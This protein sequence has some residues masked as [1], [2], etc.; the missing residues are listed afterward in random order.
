[1]KKRLNLKE[2]MLIGFTLFSMFFGAGNLIFPPLVGLQ[3]GTDAV[4]AMAGLLLSAV[5][6]PILG[7]AAVARCGGLDRLAGRVHPMFAAV[8]TLLI[9][10]MIGPGL[11]IPRT[12]STSFEMAAAPFLGSMG[13]ESGTRT[14]VM[15]VYSILF[16]GIAFFFA[17]RP[18][19]LKDMLGKIMTPVLL[20]LIAVVF[21]G[22]LLGEKGVTASPTAGYET[23]AAVKG[24]VDG[25]QT[26]DTIA[27]LNFG[28]VIAMNIRGMGIEK[29]ENISGETIRAGGIAGL[30][31]AVVYSCLAYVGVTA[32]GFEQTAS[33][34]ADVLTF[35]VHRLFGTAG[36]VIIALI[37]FIA[38]LNVC[39]GLLSCCSEYFSQ[40]FPAL[41][42]RGWLVLFA[43]ASLIVSNAGLNTIIR[44]SAPALGMIYP[45]AIVLIVLAFL[46]GRLGKSRLFCRAAVAVTAVW[47]VGSGILALIGR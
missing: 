38:C 19:R 24:F 35:M 33:N 23:L 36:T 39:I 12:A 37:F 29:E 47:S 10:L 25:Y 46:P 41:G 30:L 22:S 20:A 43:G 42:Y 26:M 2:R 40:T 3:A 34:G 45:V 7:V 21:L 28:I 44:V 13:A 6:L 14:A 17:L 9:Y 32:S 8:F 5:G 11:A 4:P 16:F 27:A 31:L 15:A 18:E 1:M